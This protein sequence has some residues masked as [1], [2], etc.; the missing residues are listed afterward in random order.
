VA[1]V[2]ALGSD[3]V[4]RNE[5]M[6]NGGYPEMLALGALLAALTAELV[7][8]AR[9]P[10]WYA[11][12]GL[13]AGLVIWADP[14]IL[15]YTATLGLVVA[16]L[17]WRH[18]LRWGGLGLLA[19]AAAGIA[20]ML[21]YN[22]HAADGQ[23]TV[24]AVLAFDDL[25]TEAGWWSRYHSAVLVNVPRATGMCAPECASWQLWW[26]FA[27]Q[28]LLLAAV[29][30]AIAGAA[31][32]GQQGRRARVRSAILVALAL[33]AAVTIMLYARSPRAVQD[34]F[35]NA[36][37]LSNLLISTP[38][39]LWPLWTLA[40]RVRLVA[41]APVLATGLAATIAVFTSAWP[42]ARADTDTLAALVSTLDRVGADRVYTD[43]QLCHRLVYVTH[44]R[45]I[46]ATLDH[47][48]TRGWDRY[49]PYRE[50]VDRA[51][52]V[53]YVL[54]A[55]EPMDHQLRAHLASAGVA[56]P[57]TEV[58]GYR[59]YQPERRLDVPH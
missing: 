30:L 52:R 33:A 8:V 45:I 49:P 39:V 16:A 34:P 43:F 44:E 4:L 28:A 50:T 55:D 13:V 3:R 29:G 2:L 26:A 35:W 9:N 1:G 5:L 24:T 58:A 23:D 54:R 11:A 32:A 53:A 19:G 15:P 27:Y 14:L 57:V 40:R 48:L 47:D 42:V 7:L 17:R 31:T 10:A 20:P 56:A 6:A 41:L 46:C 38:A 25:Q 51:P 36:R 59:I 21:W 22:A 18:L 37:Y 12:W